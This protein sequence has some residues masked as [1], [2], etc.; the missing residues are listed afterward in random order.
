MSSEQALLHATRSRWLT[1]RESEV[2]SPS[3]VA[4]E[5]CCQAAVRQVVLGDD[6]QTRGSFVEPVNDSR[7]LHAA[8]ARE[9]THVMQESIHERSIWMTRA[10]VDDATGYLVDDKDV[11]VLVDQV[12]GQ[13]LGHHF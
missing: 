12:Q 8:N 9:V 2:G 5:L 10:R 1:E 6:E 3:A 4:G 11:A 7:S 13:V